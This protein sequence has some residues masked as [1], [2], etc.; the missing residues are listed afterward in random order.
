MARTTV[1]AARKSVGVGLRTVGVLIWSSPIK[2]KD[3]AAPRA[4][5]RAAGTLPIVV[6][7]PRQGRGSEHVTMEERMLGLNQTGPMPQ[8][9]RL[10][11]LLDE[12][13]AEAEAAYL[14]RRA[15]RQRG[16]RT[17]LSGLDQALGGAIPRGPNVIHGGPGAGKSALGLQ[18][19]ATCGAPSLIVSCEMAPLALLRR[20]IA[21]ET[22]THLGRLA[23][24]ELEPREARALAR[25]ALENLAHL[26]IVDATQAFAD[27]EWLLQA[28]EAVRG[29]DE[30]LF[31]VVDSVNSWSDGAPGD[32]PEYERV[33]VAVDALRTLAATLSCPILAVAERNRASMERGGLSAGAGS[34]KLE[35]AAETVWDLQRNLDVAPNAAGEVPV[36]LKL[37]KNRNGAAG[38]KVDLRFHGG[39]QRFR[40]A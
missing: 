6:I 20:L 7:E 33:S 38:R 34:R 40:E 27:P 14:A 19:A 18:V 36:T 10:G 8:L 3:E 25:R 26:A 11:D 9:F 35:Y 24:G 1:G 37:A 5:S 4:P 30:H 15:N 16:P 21:R 32:V 13:D 2:S 23:S 39:L 29:D 28:A 31:I 12:W 17:G 22:G